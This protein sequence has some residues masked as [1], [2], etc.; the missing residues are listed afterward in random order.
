AVLPGVR[1]LGLLSLRLSS[2]DRSSA[3]GVPFEEF[4]LRFCIC[5]KTILDG[6]A[7][8]DLSRRCS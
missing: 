5:R 4:G 6:E 7:A 2:L 1:G 3:I 8:G